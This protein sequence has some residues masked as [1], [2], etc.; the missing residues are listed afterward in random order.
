VVPHPDDEA[1]LF[2]GLIATQRARGV[3]VTI[4][5]VTDGEAA[6][7][8]VEPTALARTR[9]C[10]QDASLSRLGVDPRFVH[11][12]GIP[13][14][15]VE[16]H[17]DVVADAVAAVGDPLVMAPWEL[18]HHTDHE[19]CGRAAQMGSTGRGIDVWSGL[20]WA[21]H[22]T[23]PDRMDDRQLVHLPLDGAAR[24]VRRHALD[25]HRSQF[26]HGGGVPVLTQEFLEPVG[27][28]REYFVMPARAARPMVVA[29]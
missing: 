13:D 25:A 29:R 9:R 17:L 4:I 1:L 24:T 16:L 10:E 5:A 21:W 28:G 8:D 19:A 15:E 27:W 23:D 22:H 7:P 12:L 6:Y 14:G 11:R 20:F 2:G 3:P 26:T 18:D